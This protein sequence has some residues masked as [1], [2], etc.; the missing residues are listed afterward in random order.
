MVNLSYLS[1]IYHISRRWFDIPLMVVFMSLIGK[2][3]VVKEKKQ[4]A[5]FAVRTGDYLHYM[6][7]S[8]E[9]KGQG[10]GKRLFLKI[11]PK[12]KS[13]CVKVRNYRAVRFY[14][15]FGFRIAKREAW[16]TGPRY[17]MERS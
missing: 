5:G 10:Y 3:V 4:V 17:I 2:T 11:L 16:I 15:S 6:A 14:K 12:I 9:Y 1:Q 8:A 13:L 7:V